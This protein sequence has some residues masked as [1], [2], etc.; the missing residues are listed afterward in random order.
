MS[1]VACCW[2]TPLDFHVLLKTCRRTL[3][4]TSPRRP[5]E[6]EAPS[7]RTTAW[8]L[9]TRAR[10]PVPCKTTK[11]KP[12]HHPKKRFQ[13]L[14]KIGWRS[15]LPF[16]PATRRH[17][18]NSKLSHELRHLNTFEFDRGRLGTLSLCRPSI[19]DEALDAYSKIPGLPSQRR[20]RR[21]VITCLTVFCTSITSLKRLITAC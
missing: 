7:L 9:R 4:K 10:G 3:L 6:S 18:E 19:Y 14:F 2:P 15:C 16:V 13:T 21:D 1:R 11:R 17:H 12:S 5:A 8:N 20:R